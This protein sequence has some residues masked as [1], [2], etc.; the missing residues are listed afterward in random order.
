MLLRREG[1]REEEQLKK[2]RNCGIQ[3]HFAFKVK[4]NENNERKEKKN[5]KLPANT[6]I[7]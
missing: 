5:D 2:F 3:F 1:E 7:Y 6:R 4:T